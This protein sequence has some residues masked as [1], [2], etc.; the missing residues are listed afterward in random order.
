MK[1]LKLLGLILVTVGLIIGISYIPDIKEMV[2]PQHR[3]DMICQTERGAGNDEQVQMRNLY[4]RLSEVDLTFAEV[5][6]LNSLVSAHPEYV[7]TLCLDAYKIKAYNDVV[8]VILDWK[9]TKDTWRY[10]RFKGMV[11]ASPLEQI[12]KEYVACLCDVNINHDIDAVKKYFQAHADDFQSFQDLEKLPESI[13][14][15]SAP[16]TT[17]PQKQ[18]QPAK[19]ESSAKG[20]N[21]QGANGGSGSTKS[22]NVMIPN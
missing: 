11:N 4:A 6:E 13:K 2:F 16:E 1:I 17:K 8:S 20:T 5:K 3:D 9:T 22:G 14:S 21:T 7:D 18:S 12:H 10:T 19:S 15:A